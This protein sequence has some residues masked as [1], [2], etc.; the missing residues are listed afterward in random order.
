MGRHLELSERRR[1]SARK[2]RRGKRVMREA[3]RIKY[4]AA[5]ARPRLDELTFVTFKVRMAALNG[6]KCIDHIDRQFPESLWCKLL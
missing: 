2:K 5:R 6:V 4:K 1:A 3:T